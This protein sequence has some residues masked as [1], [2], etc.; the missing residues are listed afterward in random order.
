M[1]NQ[2]INPSKKSQLYTKELKTMYYGSKEQRFEIFKKQFM[3]ANTPEAQTIKI[4]SYYPTGDL[5]SCITE[6]AQTFPT[7]FQCS[8]EEA[9]FIRQNL[10]ESSFFKR[11]YREVAKECILAERCFAVPLIRLEANVNDDGKEYLTFDLEILPYEKCLDYYDSMT[12]KLNKLVYETEVQV[13]D[14]FGNVVDA[15]KR[16][17][18]TMDKIQTEWTNNGSRIVGVEPKTVE[19]M[20]K[21]WEIFPVFLF[22]SI[23]LG[24]KPLAYDLIETQMQIENFNYNVEQAVNYYGS[25]LTVIKGLLGRGM[26]AGTAIAPN[27][28]VELVGEEDLEIKTPNIQ[29]E[30]FNSHMTKKVDRLYMQAGLMPPSLRERTFGTDSSAVT[31]LAQASLINQVKTIMSFHKN[32]LNQMARAVLLLNGK[33]YTN[34]KISMPE[35]ILP[36]DLGTLLNSYAI[37]QSLGLTDDEF[38]WDKYFPS[39]S[40]IERDRIRAFWKERYGTEQAADMTNVNNTAKVPTK[41]RGNKKQASSSKETNDKAVTKE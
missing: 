14:S 9:D 18:Y 5:K 21:E 32:P 31:K 25:P 34:E 4:H 12:G 36:I 41:P 28:I 35:E 29:L 6:M 1:L 27:A 16:T 7:D 38:F 17:T 2:S 20:F 8:G 24:E 19:N 23:S 15:T 40:R 37:S 30:S 33:A 26:F 10:I 13:Y 11:A 3:P 22:E 39:M